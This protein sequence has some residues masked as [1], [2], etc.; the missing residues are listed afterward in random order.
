MYSDLKRMDKP[1][2]MDSLQRHV[3]MYKEAIRETAD[4][5]INDG[6][7]DY[8]VFIMHQVPIPFGES[9]IRQEEVETEWSLSAI[10]VEEMIKLGIIQVE[11]AK[12]FIS[13]FKSA[14]KQMCLFVVTK[15]K[16]AQFIFISN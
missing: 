8:P 12:Y 2:Y 3:E 13:Q 14:R 9:L 6:I 10:T 11:K 16:E 7:S 5:I 4:S 15:E 1:E